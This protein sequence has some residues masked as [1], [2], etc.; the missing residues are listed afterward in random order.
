M[1]TKW[2]EW[3]QE[4]HAIRSLTKTPRWPGGLG[5][6]SPDKSRNRIHDQRVDLPKS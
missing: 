4:A 5:I 3:D 1:N 6:I 2:R